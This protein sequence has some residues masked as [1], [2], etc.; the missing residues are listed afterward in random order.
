[1]EIIQLCFK[2]NSQVKAVAASSPKGFP[3]KTLAQSRANVYLD[4]SIPV[5]GNI[6]YV[7]APS[8]GYP[9]LMNA[10]W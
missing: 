3:A 5:K 4:E 8:T 1:M 9:C 6:L 10:D 7:L 2:W